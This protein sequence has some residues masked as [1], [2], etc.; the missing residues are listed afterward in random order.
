MG[1]PR[2]FRATYDR[3]SHPW[4]E[5]RL[6]MEKPLVQDYGL[7]NKTELYKIISKVKTYTATAERLIAST[8]AQADLEKQQLFAKLG[9]LGL[10]GTSTNLDDVLGLQPRDL[11]ERRL[12]TMVFRKGLA[13]S[14]KQARQF[15]AHEH[16]MVNGK[17]ITAPN[18][19]VTVA[20]ESMISVVPSST[21]AS[22]DHPERVPIQKK[23]KK[24]RP[25]PRDRRDRRGGRR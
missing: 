18:Y 16:I 20:E 1:D 7:K 23:A 22:P 12:Q 24:P 11:L 17:K 21:L 8:G 2:K 25:A 3:P 10:I 5:E 9:K 15:I 13:R 19:L 14:P 4:Q 6:A